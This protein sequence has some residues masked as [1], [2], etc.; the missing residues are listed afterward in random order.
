MRREKKSPLVARR[1]LSR[2]PP[3]STTFFFFFSF[4]ALLFRAPQRSRLRDVTRVHGPSG[5]DPHPGAVAVERRGGVVREDL[6]GRFFFL[7][8]FVLFVFVAAP[9]L[10]SSS[11]C[12][13]CCC[14]G[15]LLLPLLLALRLLLLL[16]LP[17]QLVLGLVSRK[18]EGEKSAGKERGERAPPRLVQKVNRASERMV[19][20]NCAGSLLSFLLRP[21]LLSLLLRL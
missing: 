2:L 17:P 6:R 1:F 15:R 14:S 20:T 12:C 10:A 9:L 8:L 11:S 5:L 16:L 19:C 21:L 7:L 13:C 4:A 18:H 3:P